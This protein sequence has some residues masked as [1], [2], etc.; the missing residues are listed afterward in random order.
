MKLL[1]TRTLKLEA[2][3]VIGPSQRVSYL[4]NISKYTK[5]ASTTFLI[6]M[7]MYK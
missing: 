1:R 7:Y 5:N 3:I 4:Q 6:V 2:T